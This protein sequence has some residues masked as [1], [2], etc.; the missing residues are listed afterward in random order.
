MIPRAGDV[1]QAGCAILHGCG[2]NPFNPTNRVGKIT[3]SP[4]MW[5]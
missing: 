5:R 4:R 2:D 1:I 3:Y